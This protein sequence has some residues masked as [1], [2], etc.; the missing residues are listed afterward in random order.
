MH[1]TTA[2][3]IHGKEKPYARHRADD[4][5]DGGVFHMFIHES[6]KLPDSKSCDQCKQHGHSHGI[7]KTGHD[8]CHENDACDGSYNQ[9]L[10]IM[11]LVYGR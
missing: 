5:V 9:I 8:G 4:A 10:H 11:L 2:E 6:G 1:D 7:Q 3:S